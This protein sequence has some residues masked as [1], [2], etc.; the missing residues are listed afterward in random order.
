MNVKFSFDTEKITVK[1]IG[2]IGSET[3]RFVELGGG[4]I[5]A[6]QAYIAASGST[7]ITGDLVEIDNT[8]EEE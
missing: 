7:G 8:A 6:M 5:S 4:G 3:F 2:D 1:N